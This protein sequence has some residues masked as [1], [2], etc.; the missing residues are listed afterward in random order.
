MLHE[1]KSVM[2]QC[3]QHGY[4]LWIIRYNFYSSKLDPKIYN[5]VWLLKFINRP[6]MRNNDGPQIDLSFI[7]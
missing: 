7:L 1:W 3:L 6:K 2:N 4:N 5:W